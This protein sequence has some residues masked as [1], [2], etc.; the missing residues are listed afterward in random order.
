[1][2]LVQVGL[3]DIFNGGERKWDVSLLCWKFT[4]PKYLPF[5]ISCLSFIGKGDVFFGTKWMPYHS[6]TTFLGVIWLNCELVAM[7]TLGVTNGSSWWIMG[8]EQSEGGHKWCSCHLN[9]DPWIFDLMQAFSMSIPPFLLLF[10]EVDIP[11]ATFHLN[12]IMIYIKYKSCWL[13][14]LFCFFRICIVTLQV[15]PTYL[16]SQLS[17]PF[18]AKI[19]KLVNNNQIEG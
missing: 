6:I 13:I 14:S 19:N 12:V 15:S 18:F 10:F 5:F 8:H 17:V 11:F 1:M 2:A 3:K 9:Q 7:T 16:H 4:T